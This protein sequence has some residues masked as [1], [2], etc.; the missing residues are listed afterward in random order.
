MAKTSWTNWIQNR[1]ERFRFWAVNG[2]SWPS[3]SFSASSNGQRNAF[4]GPQSKVWHCLCNGNWCMPRQLLF[5]RSPWGC[6]CH[7]NVIQ[8]WPTRFVLLSALSTNR[9]WTEWEG[10]HFLISS[11]CM[12]LA[13][14]WGTACIWCHQLLC[15]LRGFRQLEL[16]HLSW[17]QSHCSLWFDCIRHLGLEFT[18]QLISAFYRSASRGSQ[19][20]RQC[21]RLWTH[22]FK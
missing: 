9:R 16:Y 7:L 3:L 2:T 13:L 5:V 6:T 19:N 1:L 21:L 14:E 17:W 18:H 12:S 10:R 15:L 11:T 20:C 4:W 8:I 22:H